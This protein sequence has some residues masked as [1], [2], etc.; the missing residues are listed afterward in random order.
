MFYAV[1]LFIF[2]WVLFIALA[3]SLANLFSSVSP[4]NL[5]FYQANKLARL[6]DL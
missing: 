6:T 3:A 1:F 5:P 2:V 4:F